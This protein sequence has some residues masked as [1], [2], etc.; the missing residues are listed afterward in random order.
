MWMQD[1]TMSSFGLAVTI[2]LFG[3]LGRKPFQFYDAFFF[4]SFHPYCRFRE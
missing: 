2:R 3:V 1:A 4:N